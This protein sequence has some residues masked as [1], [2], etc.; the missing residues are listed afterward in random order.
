MVSCQVTD[1]DLTSVLS[2]PW[3]LLTAFWQWKR[4]VASRLRVT[5]IGDSWERLVAALQCQSIERLV[6]ERQGCLSLLERQ[7]QDRKSLLQEICRGNGNGATPARDLVAGLRV[8]LRQKTCSGKTVSIGTLL[9]MAHTRYE[10][11]TRRWCSVPI[12][13]A[14]GPRRKRESEIH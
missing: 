1:N 4:P 7:E 11:T 10:R 2:L 13:R 5:A 12:L 6:V 8:W 14:E 3:V 9:I